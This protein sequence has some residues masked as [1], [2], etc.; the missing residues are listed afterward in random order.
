[1][2]TFFFVQPYR[3]KHQRFVPAGAMTFEDEAGAAVAGL[4]AARFRPG[5][6]VLSQDVDG[7]TGFRGKPRVIAI[8]GR[9]PDPWLAAGLRR[10]AA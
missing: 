9:V 1:M 5:V 2:R 10:D 8:H 4:R 6:V 7:R 3:I